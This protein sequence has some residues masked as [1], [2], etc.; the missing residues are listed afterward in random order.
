MLSKG[1][2]LVLSGFLQQNL[3]QLVQGALLQ[4]KRRIAFFAQQEWKV[5]CRPLSDPCAC[6]RVTVCELLCMCECVFVCVCVCVCVRER[7]CV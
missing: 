4:G 6:V 1:V 2:F 5:M 3:L 7:V